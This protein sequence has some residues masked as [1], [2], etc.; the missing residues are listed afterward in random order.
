MTPAPR[1]TLAPKSG[2]KTFQVNGDRLNSLYRECRLVTVRGNENAAA[3][4]LRVFIELSSEALLV[5][6]SV[7]LPANATR[8]TRTKWSDFGI[9]LATKIQ[10]VADF[11]DPSKRGKDFQ[12]A[13]VACDPNSQATFAVNTLHSYFHNLQMKPDAT[14]LTEAWDAWENYLRLLHGAR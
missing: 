14:A 13:R 12:Q 11:L 9:T 10:A 7:P 5:E 8:G 1:A 6:K 4:L 3:F 2:P